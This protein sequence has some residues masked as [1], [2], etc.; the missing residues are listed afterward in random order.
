MGEFIPV[1]EP[2]DVCGARHEVTA[3]EQV[4]EVKAVVEVKGFEQVVGDN[5]FGEVYFTLHIMKFLVGGS[6]KFDS[7]EEDLVVSP[8]FVDVVALSGW[9]DAFDGVG[10]ALAVNGFLV[11]LDGED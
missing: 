10:V 11:G 8:K 4:E 6:N 5:G 9:D 3:G 7:V 2:D 1:D